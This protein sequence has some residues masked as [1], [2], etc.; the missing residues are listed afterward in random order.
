MSF[1]LG[2]RDR[3]MSSRARSPA[4][5][6][7]D[8]SD[9][10]M[11]GKSSRLPKR[12]VACFIGYCGTGYAGLQLNPPHPTIESAFFDAFVKAGAVS[13]ENSDDPKK[14]ALQ[15]SARTDKGVHAAVNVLALKMIIEDPDIVLKVNQHLPEQM[16]LWKIERTTKS[17]SP[18]NHCDSRWYEYL[19]PSL[20]FL[21]P[22]KGSP[23]GKR[24]LECNGGRMLRDEAANFWDDIPWICSNDGVDA[25][26]EI[27]ANKEAVRLARRKYRI[28]AE[29]LSAVRQFLSRFVGTRNFHNYT[30]DQDFR[31]SNSLR[32]IR[33]FTASEP[34]LIDNTQWISLKIHGQ[35]FML[36][37][38]R[39]M[40][41]MVICAV[42]CGCSDTA[43]DETF[44]EKRVNI[45]KA[46][47]LGLLLERP[48][49]EGY[50]RNIA[51]K[52]DDRST[53]GIDE[54]V[55]Q[56]ETFKQ[57]RIYDK[58]YA[59]EEQENTFAS[60]TSGLDGHGARGTLDFLLDEIIAPIATV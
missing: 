32:V 20:S 52:H 43:F 8:V 36:H 51:S 30:V 31:A 50:N 26:A 41:A 16:R 7:T 39:K 22:R 60:F 37:Q 27:K 38:I 40:V 53:I 6:R 56:I 54:L 21:P 45:P 17:F 14:V 48:V 3:P 18:R 2:K 13:K 29:R 10:S 1:S 28:S 15:R 5:K 46:P 24:I 49:F 47:S 9:E 12:K 25:A 59:T 33:S 42:R 35:S 44:K 4:A 58:L 57:E 23:W 34:F 55:E 19:I 11:G